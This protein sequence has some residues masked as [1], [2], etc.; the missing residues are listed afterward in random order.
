MATLSETFEKLTQHLKRIDRLSSISELLAWD[1]Q[2]NL[3]SGSAGLR[4]EQASLMAE[5]THKE[6]SS[7][8]LGQ[9]IDRLKAAEAELNPAQ[10]AILRDAR[11]NYREATCL[12]SAFVRRRSKAHSEG[13]QAWLRAKEAGDFQAFLPS[14]KT[15]IE[16]AREQA[17][18]LDA[19]DPY[20]YWLD[21]FDPGLN[22]ATV[23][24]VFAPLRAD[25]KVLLNSIQT[26]P[27]EAPSFSLKGFPVDRQEAF[28]REVVTAFGFDFKRGRLDRSVHPFC[29]GHPLDLRMTTRFDPDNP[30]DSLSSAAHECGHALYEQGLPKE[31]LGTA[32]GQAVGMAVHESQSRL[33]ENQ[34]ARSRAFWQAWEM[35]YRAHFPTQLDGLNSEQLY[36]Q[37][38]RVAVTPIRVD[39]DEVT[40]NLH[41][42]LRYELEKQ[43]I[44]G[45]LDPA[46][47]P[48]A[49][50]ALS[51][52]ILGYE[53]KN[54]AEGCLQDVHWS[55]GAFGY[56]PSYCL[57]NVIC[58]Q[59][60]E[61]IQA[62]IPRLDHQI[63][64]KNYGPLRHWLRTQVHSLGRQYLTQDFVRKVTGTALSHEPLMRYLRERYGSLYRVG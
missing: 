5:L 26:A 44:G 49:W 4:A 59:L 18:L 53:P 17:S 22:Q 21:Q 38:N 3:P 62:A 24:Q 61:T 7:L 58:A 6:S 52:E 11:R 35:D 37:I 12:P 42:M 57:G 2:V 34:V 47:L 46:D 33:W 56:F 13:F 30:L 19:S 8:A 51:I 27:V 45:A 60:W 14:L 29:G 48:E 63:A 9:W 54:D 25:L 41:I 31:H 20:S 32:L 43:L 50:N 28:L 55:G 16:L 15:N 10:Q 64:S 39:A 40:Y 23:E 36:F 1:E